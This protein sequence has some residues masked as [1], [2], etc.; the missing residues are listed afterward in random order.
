M[1][2]IIST[3]AVF[4]AAAM[5][6]AQG[7]LPGSEYTT[8]D[9]VWQDDFNGNSLNMKDWNFE[10][11]APGWVNAELQSYG[12]SSEN[13]YVKD[14]CLVIQA[15]KNGN[16][17]TSGRINTMGKHN[18]KYGRFEAR[19]KVPSGKGF[20]PAFWMM[21]VNEALYG[22]WPKC[23][24]IDIM[25]VLGNDTTRNFGTLHFGE[26]H[27]QR[28]GSCVLPSGDYSKE[29]H[30]FACE[31]EPGEIRFYVDGKMYYKANEWFTKRSSSEKRPYPAPYNQPF[32]LIL[33]VAVGGSWP[34]N[35]DATTKFDENARMVVD[36]VKVYQKKSY[37]EN[38][39]DPALNVVLRNPDKDG[40]YVINGN[41]ASSEDLSNG[42]GWDFYMTGGGKGSASIGGGELK[43]VTDNAGTLDYSIQIF[44][45]DIPVEKGCT[46][47]FSFDAYADSPR[48]II[49]AVSAP[50]RNWI[51]YFPDTKLKLT[52][53]W[54]NY[55]YTY[56]MKDDSD[57]K[58]RIEF[59]MGNLGSTATVHIKNV[60][61]KKIK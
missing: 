31:W 11:H 59:N 43:I 10:F 45:T 44:Q 49:A 55:K 22:Q 34:G 4:I 61:V 25:E 26:P 24:E 54:Q 37:D 8:A 58:G 20:L 52:K 30:V 48:T 18:F 19:L 56:T 27:T 35:P 60:V 33:N 32:Y 39:V 53:S 16:K 40:N 15:K 41:F 1:K 7:K 12:D 38:V 36:Y 51:R 42:T 5:V 3:A 21:P 9:L 23:G 13:T 50:E 47:E 57:P 46:Y 17:Y 6:F 29:F 28:Q 14:G 2:K